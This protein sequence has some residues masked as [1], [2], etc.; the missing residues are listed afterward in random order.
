[1]TAVFRSYI[2][3]AELS[4]GALYALLLS[5]LPLPAVFAASAALS[6]ASAALARYL[7]RGL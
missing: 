5:F 4:N 1:M 7:P 3:V 2:E 6:L